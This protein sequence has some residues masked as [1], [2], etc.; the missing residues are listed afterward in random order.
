[1]SPAV[2]IPILSNGAN[3]IKQQHHIPNQG[4]RIIIVGG[5]IGGLT[6]AIA[7]RNQGHHVAVYE[8]SRFANEIG[9][10]IHMTPNA[11]GALK[12]IGIDPRDAGAV[13]LE[14]VHFSSLVQ[15]RFQLTQML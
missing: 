3:G 1:M 11:M 12:Y 6:A 9:A 14:L 4:L 8:Q 5:G 13:K 10:A 2:E 15:Q 7:L